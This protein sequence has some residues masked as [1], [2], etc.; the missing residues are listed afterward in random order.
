MARK[1]HPLATRPLRDARPARGHRR[2]RVLTL[3]GDP[4]VGAANEAPTAPHATAP[5][6]GAALPGGPARFWDLRR[7]RVA[8]VIGLVLSVLA[9]GVL[10]PFRLSF[11]PDVALK[12]VDGELAIPVDLLGE[13]TPPAPPPPPPPPDPAPAAD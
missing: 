4:R 3:R 2:P 8:L 5:A 12:D 9:H 7:L 11:L 6:P 10:V 1:T 13:D